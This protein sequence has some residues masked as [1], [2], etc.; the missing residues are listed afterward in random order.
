M[1]NKETQFQLLVYERCYMRPVDKF[2]CLEWSINKEGTK[3]ERK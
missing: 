1:I 3:E 2:K